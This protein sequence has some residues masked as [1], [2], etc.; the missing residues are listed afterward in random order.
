MP[1]SS[2]DSQPGSDSI[3][4]VDLWRF[5]WF[6][7]ICVMAACG[8]AQVYQMN[9]QSEYEVNARLLVKNT[10]LPG[11]D[12]RGEAYRRDFIPTQAEIVGSPAVIEQAL[13][14]LKALDDIS[15]ELSVS[16]VKE[17]LQVQVIAGTNVLNLRYRDTNEKQA[18]FVIERLI[19]S[20]N[21]F[22]STLERSK[23]EREVAMF[24]EREAELAGKI[25]NL[26]N[27]LSEFDA[28]DPTK[29]IGAE[30]AQ[31][32]RSLMRELV[33][34]VVEAKKRHIQIEKY[35]DTYLVVAMIER[36]RESNIALT[37]GLG[38]AETLSVSSRSEKSSLQSLADQ[39]KKNQ[40]LDM[41][42]T[43][44]KSGE[45]NVD[46]PTPLRKK[47]I[48]TELLLT[49][50][51]QR[52]SH[53]HPHVVALRNQIETIERRLQMSIDSLPTI[54]QDELDAC[55]KS[56]RQLKI[57]FDE[58]LSFMHQ[59]DSNIV[60]ENDQR[61]EIQRLQTSHD[62]A[63]EQLRLAGLVQ[64][65]QENRPIG[66]SVQI[67]ESPTLSDQKLKLSPKVLSALSTGFGL[68]GGVLCLPTLVRFRRK[69]TN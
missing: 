57:H 51:S 22:L 69:S 32:Q 6:L 19:E 52:F 4:F 33:E 50:V 5:K 47:L 31:V 53:K 34:S 13:A 49:D 66:T 10:G 56:N 17:N 20:Y 46:D 62:T 27:Q 26:Q 18:G 45:I 37:G 54:L 11:D 21:S 2:T 24:S 41:I 3:R 39:V 60:K 58:Q 36:R 61:E 64:Q 9:S 30:G 8:L 67:I 38:G 68:L 28:A 15:S 1:T 42:T 23:I 29:G 35:L 59:I 43:L 12:T 44:A 40:E 55:E 48:E 63:F 14:Q 25:A 65:N 16:D 7:L